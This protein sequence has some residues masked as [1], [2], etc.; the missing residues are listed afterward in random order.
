MNSPMLI[1]MRAVHLLFWLMKSQD[2]NSQLLAS[3]E[4]IFEEEET[5]RKVL[6]EVVRNIKEEG[7]LIYFFLIFYFVI[8]DFA[9]ISCFNDILYLC[10]L[11][12]LLAFY[13]YDI[14]YLCLLFS[15]LAFNSL[16][17]HTYFFSFLFFF[18]LLR[19]LRR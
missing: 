3:D 4:R 15:L 18:L 6:K 10:Y 13:S 7:F 2:L 8:S 1:Y 16:F 12:S 14:L 11:F 5:S 9:I 17:S 19:P